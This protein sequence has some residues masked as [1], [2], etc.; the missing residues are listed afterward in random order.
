MGVI[1]KLL[2]TFCASGNSSLGTW[3]KNKLSFIPAGSSME[4]SV[5][6]IMIKTTFLWETQNSISNTVLGFVTSYENTS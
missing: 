1:S 2:H 4:K 6:K 5:Y 3:Y